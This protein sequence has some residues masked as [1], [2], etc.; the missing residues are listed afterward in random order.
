MNVIFHSIDRGLIMINKTNNDFKRLDF[1]STKD[2]NF[3]IYTVLLILKNIKISNSIKSFN[4]YRKLS[5]ITLII[6]NNNFFNYFSNYYNKTNEINRN[7]L[8]EIRNLY[9]QGLY[10]NENLKLILILLE[11]NEF[12]K[13]IKD[14][15]KKMTNIILLHNEKIQI[16]ENELFYDNIAY[17]K[18]LKEIESHITSIK[19]ETFVQRLFPKEV[20]ING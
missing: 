13:I 5:Y 20:M 14:E 9:Y 3:L 18:R 1:S 7:L 2:L 12:I 8:P 19:Y 10:N 6:S 16:L 11:K 17:I 4:D 15:D